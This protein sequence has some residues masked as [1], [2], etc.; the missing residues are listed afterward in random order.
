MEAINM[1]QLSVEERKILEGRYLEGYRFI[2]RDSFLDLEAH[3][4][5][6]EKGDIF[7]EGSGRIIG[8]G[9]TY[10]KFITW[11]D[12]E[13]QKIEKLLDIKEGDLNEI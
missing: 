4:F 5:K 1:Q 3:Y 11:N 8:N 9:A 12:K 7:W 6:P 13:P 10:F 2:T